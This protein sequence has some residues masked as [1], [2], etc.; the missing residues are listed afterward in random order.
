MFIKSNRQEPKSCLSEN[1]ICYKPGGI[2]LLKS[3]KGEKDLLFFLPCFFFSLFDLSCSMSSLAP[4][5]EVI[6]TSVL[7]RFFHIA[8][9]GKKK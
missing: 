1:F 9:E 7:C 5:F 3:L 6:S 4:P 8:V 2:L